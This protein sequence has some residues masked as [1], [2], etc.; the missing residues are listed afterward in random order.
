MLLRILSLC[1]LC[2][3]SAFSAEVHYDCAQF[4]KEGLA[5]DP[6]LAETRFSTDEKQNKLSAIKYG[7]ILPKFEA[8]MLVGPAPGLKDAVNDWGDTVETWDFTKMGPFFGA[9]VKAVQ[10]LNYGQ[11]KVGKKAA[12]AD[13]RQQQMK[14][15]GAEN[16]K[17]VELQGYYYNYLYAQ[18]ML[19]LAQDAKTQVDKAYAKMEEALDEDEED[20]EEDSADSASS[21]KKRGKVSQMDFLQLKAQR[22]VV[23]EAMIDAQSGL[24]QLKLAVKFSLN[25][26]DGD[27]FA[28]A[29]S[30]L[31][32]RP[33][34]LPSLDD[35]KN[36]ALSR[37][38]ELK[39]LN[40]GLSARSY[41]MELAE[42]KLGPEFFI[43]GEFTYA[44][45]WAGSRKEIQKDAFAQD[46]VNKITGTVGIGVQYKLNFWN[47]WES[48]KSARSD[49]RALK[50]KGDYAT[51]GIQMRVE[52]QYLKVT[53]LKAKVESLDKSMR[54]SAAILKGAAIQY[55][56]DP[57]DTGPLVSAYK[58]NLELQKD[59]YSAVCKYNI[60]F[61]ELLS[62]IGIPLSE[63][64][65]LQGESK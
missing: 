35:A 42:T 6:Q 62:R 1:F 3:F 65:S 22:H 13:L 36:M 55:D 29:D 17:S 48:Y 14:V 15:A 38:P 8:D 47:S 33:E 20:D 40:A 32:M 61:A 58:Q 4:V 63:Y 43:M 26:Q 19:K 30:S 2:A 49:Y 11:Y 37:S 23:D 21:G 52:E 18:E 34:P 53:A 41:Q 45:S 64:Q 9:Q 10:P 39:R 56:L 60:A 44:K 28:P 59:Y 24:D 46:A 57:S 16:D 50:L 51:E 25:L 12:E 31:T 27:T 54:A 5:R 7:A